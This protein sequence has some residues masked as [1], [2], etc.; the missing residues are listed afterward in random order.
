MK[1]RNEKECLK[2][3]A[4]DTIVMV[5]SDSRGIDTA[6]GVTALYK[7]TKSFD[8]KFTSQIQPIS[9]TAI[10]MGHFEL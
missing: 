3:L 6:L 7:I 4:Y 10:L 2:E 8:F 9:H 5:I 1:R